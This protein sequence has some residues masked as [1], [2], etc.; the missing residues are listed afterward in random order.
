MPSLKDAA[1]TA[2][3]NEV[4]RRLPGFNGSWVFLVPK[5]PPLS[6]DTIGS[7]MGCLGRIVAEY[8]VLIAPRKS[9][10][11]EEFVA[12]DSKQL[13]KLRDAL[14]AKTS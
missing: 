12:F 13:I 6:Y 11:P 2:I 14:V 10:G 8:Q 9:A 5:S 3:R 1:N 7:W 4:K